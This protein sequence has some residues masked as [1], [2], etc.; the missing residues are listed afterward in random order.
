MYD[1]WLLP[2]FSGFPREPRFTWGDRLIEGL[3][4][5]LELLVEVRYAAEKREL[6]R[7]ANLRLKLPSP[8][9]GCFRAA[10][11]RLSGLPGVDFPGCRVYPDHR[12]LRRCSG[13]RV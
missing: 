12:L 11:G 9:S 5:I 6:L 8:S 2:R 13:L 3:L 4:E 10:G 1:L 7:R